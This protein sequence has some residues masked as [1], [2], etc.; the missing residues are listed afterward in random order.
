M[1]ITAQLPRNVSTAAPGA[2][3]FP[4]NFKVFDKSELLVQV[5]GATK[6]I[7]VDF[8]ADG[9]GN[10]GGGSIHFVAAMV[11][12]ETVMRKRNMQFQRL[13]DYQGL[14][15]LRSQT[16]NNDQDSPIAMIQQLGE[17][18]ERSIQ[19]PLDSMATAQLPPLV[20]LS[21]LVVSADGSKFEMG[22]PNHT[23]DMLLRPNL[24][25]PEDGKGAQL[26][27]FLQ[28]GI[29]AIPQDMRAFG[30]ERPASPEQFGA[31]GDGVTDDT[32]ALQKWLDRAGSLEVGGKTYLT[33]PLFVR[34]NTKIQM[35]P[36]TLIKAKAGFA[37]N[38]A[39][40]TIGMVNNVTIYGSTGK[41]RMNKA[42]YITGEW[43]HTVSISGGASKIRLYDVDA[44]DSG[45]DGFY[46]GGT[47]VNTDIR[48]V[49][50]IAD[51]A[52]RNGLSI[53]NAIGCT[54][55]GGEFKNTIGTA[56]EAGIDIE[57]N[58]GDGYYLQNVVVSGV[59]TYNNNGGGISITPQSK[60]AP[61][62]ISVRDC[63]SEYDGFTNGAY[64]INSAMAYS[65]AT[66]PGYIGKIDGQIAV[67]N[68]TIINPQGA[69]VV[70]VNWTENAPTTRLKN[71]SVVNPYSNP[72]L[73]VSNRNQCGM[74]IRGELPSSGEF[75]T[76][77]GNIEVEN[78][79]CRDNR[80]AK[81][82]SIPVLIE[83]ADEAAK[84]LK[85]LKITN[86]DAI[87]SEW[88]S[89]NLTPILGSTTQPISGVRVRY[90]PEFI[91]AVGSSTLG[92]TSIGA[93][94]TNGANTTYTLPPAANFIGAEWTVRVTTPGVTHGI[95]TSGGDVIQM[96][97]YEAL[98]ALR[99][100]LV[101]GAEVKIKALA[102][103]V[104]QVTGA[105]DAANVFGSKVF[106][107]PSLATGA[108]QSTTVTATGAALGDFAEASMSVDLAGTALR[109]YVSAANTVTVVQR[110]DTGG[111]ID[112]ASGTLRVRVRKP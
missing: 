8:T 73:A 102:A 104:W 28:S 43:R 111:A 22:D 74:L 44:G 82:M 30:R 59:R 109:A 105:T 108:Q 81:A 99:T 54:V 1:A 97:G 15:D 69:G 86:I 46:V 13:T 107:W 7:D 98:A 77:V 29:G 94:L 63:T 52:R 49:N 41:F 10:D 4:Y 6:T 24:A 45:G 32:S 27:T 91:M 110:N 65:G 100:S 12:G 66:P 48:L 67:E 103:G 20:P 112:L 106:D 93:V 61:V 23:G 58:A 31:V 75:G 70:S 39:L 84:P 71:I 96:Q 55:T 79:K 47:P 25:N 17:S 62:S 50:C 76:C 83:L 9:I 95:V 101:V 68:C 88:T 53:V 14:G 42:E 33:G 51:N 35:H 57:S 60:Y 26:M 18:Q 38:D 87:K 5:D 2:K 37:T 64:K 92:S 11:G 72:A 19:L 80:A 3:D 89:A 85:N 56:P 21:A 36:A 16:V 78:L 40:L 90:E 34:S